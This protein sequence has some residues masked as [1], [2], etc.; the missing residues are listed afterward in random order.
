MSCV[1]LLSADL[2]FVGRAENARFANPG[3]IC[4]E[5]TCFVPVFRSNRKTT[6]KLLF[7][8]IGMRP[9]RSSVEYTVSEYRVQTPTT[10]TLYGR[11]YAHTA[12]GYT[13]F[14]HR[15]AQNA[16]KTHVNITHDGR[17]GGYGKISHGQHNVYINICVRCGCRIA[18]KVNDM[19]K[20]TFGERYR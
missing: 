3:E 4:R 10:H 12:R 20:N 2:V 8:Q 14:V 5:T 19:K 17:G 15:E 7:V 1:L 6:G 16:R 18:T 9:F 11:L 13:C